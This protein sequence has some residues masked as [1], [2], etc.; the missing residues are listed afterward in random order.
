MFVYIQAT[1][2]NDATTKPYAPFSISLLRTSSTFCSHDLPGI[3]KDFQS[4]K[5]DYSESQG[6]LFS[7][8][9]CSANES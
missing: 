1:S 4:H 9:T 5:I 6:S 7:P 2:S 3:Q 8:F